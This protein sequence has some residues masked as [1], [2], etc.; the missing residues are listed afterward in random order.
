MAFEELP[1]Q[2]HVVRLLRASLRSGRMPHAY[3]FLG[4]EGI[5]RCRAARGLAR[6]VLC[7]GDSPPDDAC[8]VCESC[9][10]MAAENHPDYFETGVPEGKQLLPID[11][12]R[13]VQHLAALKPRLS[14][15]RW[16][17][18]DLSARRRGGVR[19]G[20]RRGG[21]PR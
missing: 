10:R 11:S 12:V 9:R 15:R 16:S 4:A 21:A 6:V 14:A 5:G 18:T 2:P 17:L 20:Y 13:D 19:A 8:G 7:V 1:E 3:M